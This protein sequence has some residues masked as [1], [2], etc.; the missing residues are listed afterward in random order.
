VVIYD[1]RLTERPD[2]SF[3]A[4]GGQQRVL[5]PWS[6]ETGALTPIGY[7]FRLPKARP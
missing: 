4:S 6:L 7:E 3:E 2:G 5:E 1:I